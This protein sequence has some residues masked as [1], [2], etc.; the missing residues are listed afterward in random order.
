MKKPSPHGACAICGEL[1]TLTFEHVPPHG[2]YNDRRVEVLSGTQALG[3]VPGEVRRGRIS[4]R[5]VGDYYTC[6]ACN[7]AAG[8]RYV[9]EYR[10]WVEYGFG[11]LGQLEDPALLDSH[12]DGRIVDVS[13]T[14]VKPLLFLKQVAY[15]LMCVNGPSLG[16]RYPELRRF[17]LSKECTGLPEALHFHLGLI[18]GPGAR[19]VGGVAVTTTKG[20][21]MTLLS[22]VAFPPYSCVL[23]IG[24]PYEPLS[25]CEIGHFARCQ[26]DQVADVELSLRYGFSHLAFPSDYR[27]TA[28]LEKDRS[29]NL[30]GPPTE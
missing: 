12:I 20:E 30:A 17:V 15:M 4:Q 25:P 14:A 27:S 9:P 24:D 5:G 11:V 26:P 16:L 10:R 1:G 3:L 2:A 23:R 29:A 28:A 6:G 8:G 13:F 7:N 21:G 22:E 19:M 18:Y